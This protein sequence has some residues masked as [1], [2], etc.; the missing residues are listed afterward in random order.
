LNS[1][2][3]TDVFETELKPLWDLAQKGND[4]AY[5]KALA[6]I[7]KRLRRFLQAR[8]QGLPDEVED[9]VQETMIAIHN[10]RGTYDPNYPVSAWVFAIARHKMIDLLRRRGR[11]SNLHDCIDDIDES[12]FAED[13]GAYFAKRDLRQLLSKLPEAQRQAIEMSKLQKA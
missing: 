11:T 8:L 12:D 3:Q 10:K 4:A 9:L 5:A 6:L 1:S 2:P 7:S 13:D